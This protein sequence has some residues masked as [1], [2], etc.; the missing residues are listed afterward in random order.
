MHSM[1]ITYFVIPIGHHKV[2]LWTKRSTWCAKPFYTIFECR[3]LEK[4]HSLWLFELCF[5]ES[6]KRFPSKEDNSSHSTPQFMNSPSCLFWSSVCPPAARVAGVTGVGTPGEGQGGWCY[7]LV[8]LGTWHTLLRDS[9]H[10]NIAA[11]LVWCENGSAVL[12][13]PR[14]TKSLSSALPW[15]TT[16][17]TK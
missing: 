13:I 10:H 7:I 16:S 2:L 9:S 14:F 3:L 15:E 8:S 12:C 17:A 6:E 4:G 1:I 5:M 11:A